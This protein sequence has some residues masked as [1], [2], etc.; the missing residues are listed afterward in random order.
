[1]RTYALRSLVT[2]A[3]SLRFVHQCCLQWHSV[4]LS[5]DGEL[6]PAM[7]SSGRACPVSRVVPRYALLHHAA[8]RRCLLVK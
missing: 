8:H 3:R 4:A 2:K 6:E 5:W 1:M 7:L